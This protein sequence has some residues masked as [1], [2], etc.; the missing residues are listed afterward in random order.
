MQVPLQVKNG[1]YALAEDFDPAVITGNLYTYGTPVGAWKYLV[2]QDGKETSCPVQDIG[3]LMSNVQANISSLTLRDL[4]DD[5]MVDISAP[6][7]KTPEEMLD[8]PITVGEK[9]YKIGD[10]TLDGMINIIYGIASGNINIG[11]TTP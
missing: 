10:L 4:Y 1:E 2:T 11:T 5:G 9:S 7:G 3:N 8:T 6:D